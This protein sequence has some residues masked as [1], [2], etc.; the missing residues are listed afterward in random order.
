MNQTLRNNLNQLFKSWANENAIKIIPL[1]QSGSN[2][3]YYRLIGKSATAI[4]VFNKD[5]KENK[6]FT[7]FAKHFF[8]H[9]LP[10]PQILAEDLRNNIYLQED[11]GDQSLFGLLSKQGFNGEVKKYYEEA[12]ATLLKFQIGAAK[13][14]DYSVCYPRDKFDEQSIRWDLNYFKYYFLKLA[15][16]QFDESKLEKDFNT[17]AEY[18]S[19]ASATYFMYR[20]FQPR[21][22]MIKDGELHF[23]DFQGGRRGALQYDVASLLWSARANLPF[24]QREELLDYYLN[25]LKKYEEVNE[26]DFKNWYY[27]FVLIRILQ[28]LGA[29]GYRG[30]YERK[31]HFL[32]SI[33]FAI[34]NLEWIIENQKVNLK[35]DELFYMLAQ[36]INSDLKEN[37]SE[38][39]SDLLKV[40][41]TSFS[42]KNGMPTDTA[43]NGG[44][45]VF[46]CRAIHN[47]G[48][49]DE[50]KLLTGK[51]E[52]VIEFLES[53]SDADKFLKEVWKIILMSV[54][55]Y[56]ERGFKNLMINFGCTGGQHR[57]VYCA[58]KTMKYLRTKQ[59]VEVQLIHTE[60]DKREDL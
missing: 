9:R 43:G 29:Y 14:I 54:K 24:E 42:Y 31:D 25:E 47:P 55:D 33:P 10:V 20:D 19:K 1:A 50:Y 17:L 15:D 27:G 46:D 22:I 51:D 26:V 34:N 36:I 32:K 7:T 56:Q 60:L 59:G 21:N 4:A 44:G 18:L 28:T 49:Y 30:F 45:F 57:S 35:C 23:I 5:T 37:Y 8:T 13:N 16:I 6:A 58:E 53:K 2:R 38:K 12:L 39:K 11:L 48:R 52:K 3:K 41:I 40:T